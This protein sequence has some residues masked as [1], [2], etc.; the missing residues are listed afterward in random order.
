MKAVQIDSYLTSES[1]DGLLF[2]LIFSD[3]EYADKTITNTIKI[4]K[5]GDFNCI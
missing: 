5:N 1:K 2:N 3:T 4:Y